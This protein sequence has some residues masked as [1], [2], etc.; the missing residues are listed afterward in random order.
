[1]KPIFAVCMGD[2]CGVGPEI[3]LKALT[4]YQGIHD[5]ANLVVCGTREILEKTAKLLN[6]DTH[7]HTIDPEIFS[8][9]SKNSINCIDI[10]NISFEHRFGQILAECG[11]LSFNYIEK[12]IQLALAGKVN[13]I[14]TAPINK[15]SLRAAQIPFL[16]HTEML[17]KL[18]N[19]ERTM[20]LFITGSLRVFFHTRHI[21]V[22]GISAALKTDEIVDT[23]ADCIRYLEQIRIPV[24]SIALAALNPHGGESG[25]F[26]REEIDIL[27][28]AV[29]K[30]KQLG[31]KVE[32]PVPADSVFHLA[33]E[34]AYDA[35][36]SLY[37]DQGHI[38]TKTLDFHRTVSLTMGLPF[39]RTSVDHGT[40]F[41][42]AGKGIASEI[43]LV[44]AIK[45][46]VRYY[47]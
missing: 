18:T 12:A 39:L 6:I 23:L 17:T 19:S 4:E 21:P 10:D 36:L 11:Q 35:V 41:D 31:L 7:I 24:P 44:E 16:D 25:L 38:A 32:G 3:V 14:V 1:M 15:K 20:T 33:K 30:A 37:H 26:G 47:W 27:Q 45:A 5:K 13:G 42:I 9:I 34:G 43:S 29:E 2:P 8:P 46:A 22:S 40:A 28:P